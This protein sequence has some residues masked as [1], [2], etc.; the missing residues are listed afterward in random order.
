[1][2]FYEELWLIMELSLALM[3]ELL[4]SCSS[5]ELMFKAFSFIMW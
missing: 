1:M 2:L 3:N 5:C 4:F